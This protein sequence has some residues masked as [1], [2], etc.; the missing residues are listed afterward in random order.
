MLVDA[1]ISRLPDA[2]I[3]A[4]RSLVIVKL[5]LQTPYAKVVAYASI[6][7]TRLSPPNSKPARRKRVAGASRLERLLAWS[8]VCGGFQ[9]LTR[10]I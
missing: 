7:G 10:V 8:V 9:A 5:Q 2:T 4:P 6:T 3:A 1:L